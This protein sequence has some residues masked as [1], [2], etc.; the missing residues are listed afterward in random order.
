LTIP[1]VDKAFEGKQ[2]LADQELNLLIEYIALTP[3]SGDKEN[4]IKWRLTQ[5]E[6]IISYIDKSYIDTIGRSKVYPRVACNVS[7]M[8]LEA[9][10][11]KDMLSRALE[12]CDSAIALLR[13]SSRL[14]YFVEV[15]EYHLELLSKVKPYAYKK[16]QA[17]D[18]EWVELFKELYAEYDV[19]AYT[20]N[21]GYLYWE[22][23]CHSAVK[24]LEVRRNMHGLSRVKL[25]DNI[26]A[27]KTIIRY[28]REGVSPTIPV[29]RDLF[30]V[31]VCVQNINAPE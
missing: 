19:P 3:Y 21:F 10:A 6:K 23:E 15:V 13:K 17:R 8:L 4:E 25:S 18:K 7:K 22:S 26:C 12:I 5:Y 20:Q 31:W 1:N 14:F 24:V 2:L 28:E 16:L 11:P 27:D 9:D 29:I 30:D